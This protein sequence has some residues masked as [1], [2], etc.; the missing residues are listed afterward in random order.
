[1]RSL[2]MQHGGTAHCRR[3][4]QWVRTFALSVGGGLETPRVSYDSMA[5][6]LVFFC[7]YH[8]EY[9]TFGTYQWSPLSATACI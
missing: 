4:R 6:F 7:G 9:T 8:N 2:L 5:D 1:M 3:A